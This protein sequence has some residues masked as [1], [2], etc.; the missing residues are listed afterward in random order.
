MGTIRRLPVSR[1]AV[2]PEVLREI[3]RRVVEVAQPERIILF[4]SA[5]RGEMG[6]NSDV[7]LLIVVRGPVHCG[8]LSEAI[9]LNLRGFG[10]AVDAV[11]VTTEHVERYRHSHALVIKPALREGRLVYEGPP[12]C[13]PPPEF[14]IE[15][16]S[17]G[18]RMSVERFSA[19]DPREWLNRAR[20]N[21]AGARASVPGRYLEDLCF[22]AQQAAEKAIKAVLIKREI[23]F[24]YVHDLERLLRLLEQNGEEIP[25]ALWSVAGLS[26]FALAD[27]YPGEGPAPTPEEHQEYVSIAER[28]VRWAEER[29]A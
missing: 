2:A 13:R 11:V 7:D 21:L 24:P 16:E 26:R 1:R 4:G 17:L 5:A 18:D 10:E 9:S 6:P 14:W 8:R 23:E 25:P 15:G 3:L 19:D 28:A 22:E 12:G 29:I 20:S 27:R